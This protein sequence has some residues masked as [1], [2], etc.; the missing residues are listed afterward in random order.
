MSS[1][2][3]IRGPIFH[4][5]R[6]CSHKHRLGSKNILL[7]S[8]TVFGVLNRP[9][10]NN[11]RCSLSPQPTSLHHLLLEDKRRTADPVG[12]E[13]DRHLNAVGNL[14]ERNPT[15]HAVLVPIEGHGSCDFAMAAP[16]CA[17]NS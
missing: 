16:F 14:N 1:C 4:R 5:I 8:R 15:I 7:N 6:D 10:E 13:V 11:Q 12:Y 3:A 9:I 17:S 2:A